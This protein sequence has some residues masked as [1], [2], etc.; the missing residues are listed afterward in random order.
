[1]NN[2]FPHSDTLNGLQVGWM[3]DVYQSVRLIS[4]L[5]YS[6]ANISDSDDVGA[7]AVIEIPYSL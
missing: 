5:L 7:S 3:G 2:A 4:Y 6:N 1:F